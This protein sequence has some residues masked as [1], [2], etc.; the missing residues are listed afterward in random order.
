MNEREAAQLADLVTQEWANPPGRTEGAPEVDPGPPT[1][2]GAYWPL[3]SPAPVRGHP[4]NRVGFI[5]AQTLGTNLLFCFTLD[6]KPRMYLLCFDVSE[7]SAT[8]TRLST[9]AVYKTVLRLL[10]AKD[11]T[12]SQQGVLEVGASLTIVLPGK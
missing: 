9:G 6:R 1:T 2:A 7:W 8:D 10:C 12:Q 11:W 5:S 3:G 4:A